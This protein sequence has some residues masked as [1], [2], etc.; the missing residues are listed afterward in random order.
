MNVGLFFSTLATRAG[1]GFMQ[2]IAHLPLPVLRALGAGLGCLLFWVV[3]PRR[4]VVLTNLALCFP[5]I[6]AD[7]R[8]ALAR[9]SFVYFAQ[10]WLDRSWLWHGRPEVLAKRL[11][12]HGALHE[13][14]G[15][16]PTIVFSPHFYGLDAGATAI[17]MN[18]DRDFTSIYS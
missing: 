10:T 13:F 11:H 18:I 12:L 9:Q 1:I 6:S 2:L 17:N 5:E 16:A 14:D 4:R 3:V 7:D 15:H 8:D